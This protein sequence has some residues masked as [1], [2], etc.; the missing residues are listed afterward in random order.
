VY[1]DAPLLTDEE[2]IVVPG[3]QVMGVALV[4]SARAG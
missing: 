4:R 2:P 3:H 1:G